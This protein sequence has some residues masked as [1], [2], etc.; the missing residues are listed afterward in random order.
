MASTSISIDAEG[1]ESYSL[2]PPSPPWRSLKFIFIVLSCII[3]YHSTTTTITDSTSYFFPT[4]LLR[5]TDLTTPTTS[6]DDDNLEIKLATAVAALEEE[7]NIVTQLRIE[8]KTARAVTN[9]STVEKNSNDND[10]TDIN[11]LPLSSTVDCSMSAD[12]ADLCVYENLCFDI[13]DADS[14]TVIAPILLSDPILDEQLEQVDSRV[15]GG[16]RYEN[17][18]A[19]WP[20]WSIRKLV[21]K[22]FQAGYTWDYED[23]LESRPGMYAR[24]VPVSSRFSPAIAATRASGVPQVFNGDAQGPVIWTDN[25]WLAVN[26]LG[27]HLWGF[28]ASVGTPLV[29]ALVA[30]SSRSS[31]PLPPLRALF[32]GGAPGAEYLTK[33]AAKDGQPWHSDAVPNG[34]AWPFGFLNSA[35][36]FLTG[37]PPFLGSGR[38]SIHSPGGPDVRQADANRRQILD[39]WGAARISGGV[40]TD[41]TNAASVLSILLGSWAARSKAGSTSTSSVDDNST[42]PGGAVWSVPS[43]AINNINTFLSPCLGKEGMNATDMSEFERPPALGNEFIVFSVL[44]DEPMTPDGKGRAFARAIWCAVS[45]LSGNKTKIN[46]DVNVNID[47]RPLEYTDVTVTAEQEAQ[48]RSTRTPGNDDEWPLTRDIP[49]PTRLIFTSEDLPVPVDSQAALKWAMIQAFN[50]L[51]ESPDLVWSNAVRLQKGIPLI[52]QSEAGDVPLSSLVSTRRLAAFAYWLNKRKTRLCARHAV[53]IGSKETLVSGQ[54]EGNAYREW[55]TSVRK[56]LDSSPQPPLFPPLY[57]ANGGHIEDMDPGPIP[58]AGSPSSETVPILLFDRGKDTNG[59]TTSGYYGRRFHNRDAMES[60]LLKYQLNYTIIEDKDLRALTFEQH[61]ALFNTARIIIIAHSAGINNALFLP[62]RSAIIEIYSAGMWCPIFP[63]AFTASGHH[64]FPIYSNLIAPQ[65]DYAFTYGRDDYE[66]KVRGFRERCE[67]MGHV[68]GSMDPGEF[69]H[70]HTE[71]LICVVY[72]PSL[73]KLSHIPP[74]PPLSHLTP[75]YRMLARSP[76]CPCI[77]TNSRI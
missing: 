34:W 64:Y 5:Q 16:S 58:T 3:I 38:E 22:G 33:D 74:P 7:K 75:P 70:H 53:A 37:L 20:T 4:A 32:V 42:A 50:I 72:L 76:C 10:W 6:L 55:A 66:S 29:A 62:P 11:G 36:T 71:L 56:R 41:Y 9:T 26:F 68:R 49:R 19:R 25:L 48:E 46:I 13:P 35:L 65:Q 24:A 21:A 27:D 77:Y 28:S 2:P 59:I 73:F 47:A 69:Y 12:G 40:P 44:G 39:S 31:I 57:K 15:A 30:N 45:Y 8:L 14:P 63:R 60:I 67:P 54:V 18:R 23:F 52:V 61:I 1:T 43:V 51:G 17:L